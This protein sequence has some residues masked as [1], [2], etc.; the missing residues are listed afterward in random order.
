[1][2]ISHVVLFSFDWSL[3]AVNILPVCKYLRRLLS[4]KIIET[5]MFH[6]DE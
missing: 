5:D 3:K 4:F 1:M 6:F 2:L